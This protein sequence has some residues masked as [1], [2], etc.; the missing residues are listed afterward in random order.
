[1][2]PV[3]VLPAVNPVTAPRARHQDLKVPVLPNP[4][5]AAPKPKPVPTV[6]GIPKPKT[7]PT[8][9]MTRP[10]LRGPSHVPLDLMG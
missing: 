8:Y 3:H 9:G 7:K 10:I 1:M 5:R 6:A 2:D 4:I